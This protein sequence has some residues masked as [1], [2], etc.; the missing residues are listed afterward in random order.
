MKKVNTFHHCAIFGFGACMYIISFLCGEI[1][2][3]NEG[4]ML[5]HVGCGCAQGRVESVVFDA[6]P[7]RNMSQ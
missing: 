7:E 1:S 3:K 5:C 6:L 2:E 4:G